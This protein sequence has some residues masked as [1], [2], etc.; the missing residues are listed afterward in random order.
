MVNFM[1]HLDWTM[2]PRYLVK[3]YS[4]CF[5]ESV[6]WRRFIFNL[7]DFEY[8]R[9]CYIIWVGPIQSAEGLNR[10]KG[11]SSLNKREFF[12]QTAL[13]PELRLFP[14]TSGCGSPP[15]HLR[16]TMPPQLSCQIVWSGE[17]ISHKETGYC[18]G[19]AMDS[20]KTINKCPLQLCYWVP[21]A[22]CD[23]SASLP[24]SLWCAK[25][26]TWEWVF[27]NLH[28]D[29][30]NFMSIKSNNKEFGLVSCCCLVA[31]LCPTLCDPH[32][33][34][35]TRLFGPPLSPRVCSNSCPLS[36]WCYLTISS[37]ATPF[38]NL[39]FNLSQNRGLFQRVSSFIRWPKFWSFRTFL[40]Y[41]SRY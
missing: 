29:K 32:G 34:Q 33:L 12:Q 5:C 24:L 20:K 30:R 9:S 7:V 2:I 23:R 11:W 37:S 4:T 19:V 39:F 18:W 38:S 1:S 14:G 26:S 36:L 28:F 25:F 3:H 8:S 40:L 27:S 16:L 31:K 17:E 15:S 10:M 22:D 13:R 6:F 35:P 41:F 21:S